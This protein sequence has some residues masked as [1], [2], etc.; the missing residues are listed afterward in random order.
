MRNWFKKYVPSKT[1]KNHDGLSWVKGWLHHSNLWHLNRHAVARGVAIGL[2]V[3]FIPLPL[4]MLLAALLAIFTHSNLPIAVAL[5]WITNPITFLPINYFIY[6]VG[7]WILNDPVTTFVMKDFDWHGKP[8]SEIGTHFLQWMEGMSIAFLIG[9]PIVAITLSF[10]GYVLIHFIWKVSVYSRWYQ[11][12]KRIERKK[13][14]R[15]TEH[16]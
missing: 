3:A 8:W 5:T 9:L 16:H 14:A 2:F 12:K 7:K 10:L 1:I 6:R 13:K 15:R 11:R 4:Q